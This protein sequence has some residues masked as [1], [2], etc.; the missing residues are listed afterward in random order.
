MLCLFNT[1]CNVS[2]SRSCIWSQNGVWHNGHSEYLLFRKSF[3]QFKCIHW[4]QQVIGTGLLILSLSK[5]NILSKQHGH[6]SVSSTKFSLMNFKFLLFL[7]LTKFHSAFSPFLNTS[8]M[9][10]SSRSSA[11]FA[12]RNNIPTRKCSLPKVFNR[13]VKILL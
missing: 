6:S 7:F 2:N 10:S 13:I 12:N 8:K 11:T 4:K 3:W 5:C 9:V 1:L